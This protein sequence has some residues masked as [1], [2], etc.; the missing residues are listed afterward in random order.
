[1]RIVRKD[2]LSLANLAF[3]LVFFVSGFAA[4]LYQIIWQRLLTFFG[5]A[6]VYSVTI[7]VSAFMGGLGFGSLA[8]GY[9]A[10]RLSGRGR[11]LAFAGCE[12]AVAVFA[13]F[14]TNIYY[15]F[16]YV[17]LGALALPR[18]ALA[19]ITFGV[20]LWPTFFMGMSLPLAATALTQDARQPARWVPLLYGWNTLGAACGSLVAAVILFRL[21]DFTTGVRLGAL[22]SFGCALGALIALPYVQT[23]PNDTGSRNGDDLESVS[24]SRRMETS[25]SFGLRTWIAIYALSGFVALSLEILW[26][27]IL[28]V[29]V[30]SN[31]FTFGHLLGV[32][33]A[34]VGL[35]ALIGNTRR[36]RA[37]RNQPA[38]FSCCRGAFHWSPRRRWYYWW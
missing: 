38:P 28:G 25:T 32:Y 17:R 1:M 18:V 15:D 33:L 26:F 37:R 7:I 36:A 6:D 34:G 20:T 10:D 22:L 29:L 3:L 31:S 11:L 35:G 4:L 14:S 23:D 13:T 8:G 9:A 2:Q 27:R 24:A 19:A 16:L 30:K 5:G 21:V 12:L